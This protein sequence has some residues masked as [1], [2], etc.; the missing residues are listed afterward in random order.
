LY[1]IY[2]NRI[3]LSDGH[4]ISDKAT[5]KIVNKFKEPVIIGL[6]S[7]IGWGTTIMK[8]AFIAPNTI[9][10][11]KAVV[12]GK[13]NKEFTVLAGNPARIV[14]TNIVWDRRINERYGD[15]REE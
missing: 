6:H 9:V 4:V 7:W 3:F 12:A 14:K 10:A 13:F 8:N 11:A 2:R 5:G 15:G 1:V